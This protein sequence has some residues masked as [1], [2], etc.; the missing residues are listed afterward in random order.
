MTRTNITK[1]TTTMPSTEEFSQKGLPSPIFH[2]S[3]P[4]KSEPLDVLRSSV[5]PTVV[6]E[7]DATVVIT[8]MAAVVAAVVSIVM[9]SVVMGPVASTVVSTTLSIVISKGGACLGPIPE[10][11]LTARFV[12]LKLGSGATSE[13]VL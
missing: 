4:L 11:K 3:E 1:L 2:R 9:N 6:I 13:L 12:V 10:N 8:L 5:V 7:A